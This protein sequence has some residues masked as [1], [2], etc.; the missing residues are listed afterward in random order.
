[1]PGK[2]LEGNLRVAL[3]ALCSAGVL[4]ATPATAQKRGGTLRLYHND[5]PPSTSLLEESTIASVTP[6]AAVF[7]NLV[8]F[9]PAK[10]HE[11]LET[12]IPDL[13]EVLG[14][15]QHE[16]DLQAPAGREMA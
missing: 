7:N 5:T 15:L 10:P 6:F 2:R 14:F 12:V 13:A 16:V 1:M 4:A 8:I 3:I 9:D 11:S